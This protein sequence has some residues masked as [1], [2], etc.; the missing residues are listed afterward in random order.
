MNWRIIWN[1]A[2]KDWK[3]VLQNRT[4]MTSSLIL[5]VVFVI[6]IPL[7]I[8]YLPSTARSGGQSIQSL[9]AL[10]PPQ[11]SEQ[12]AGMTEQQVVVSC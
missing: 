11:I 5:P 1:I 3:E 6:V 7:I 2:V 9:V 12:V 4:A 10:M 8:I